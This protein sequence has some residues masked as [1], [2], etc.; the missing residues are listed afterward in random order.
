MNCAIASMLARV[1]GSWVLDLHAR[2][3]NNPSIC[4]PAWPH[5][6]PLTSPFP[7]SAPFTCT[8]NVEVAVAKI[9]RNRM[10]KIL[11]ER[12]EWQTRKDNAHEG[13]W[14]T[15][16]ERV[17]WTDRLLVDTALPWNRTAFGPGGAAIARWR[18]KEVLYRRECTSTGTGFP[19]CTETKQRFSECGKD[20]PGGGHNNRPELDAEWAPFVA[21][22]IKRVENDLN[23]ALDKVTAGARSWPWFKPGAQK[24]GSPPYNTYRDYT[25]G[26]FGYARRAAPSAVTLELPRGWWNADV[27]TRVG[28]WH[29]DERVT[30]WFVNDQVVGVTGSQTVDTGGNWG[31]A[32][33]KKE[34]VLKPNERITEVQV[35]AGDE[36]WWALLKTNLG[37]TIQG[38]GSDCSDRGG[39]W[40]SDIYTYGKDGCAITTRRHGEIGT[41]DGEL[42]ARGL[43]TS[44]QRIVVI[45]DSGKEGGRALGV[46]FVFRRAENHPPCFG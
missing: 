25:Q 7:S 40:G 1:P 23:T 4:R 28:F 41:S 21:G 15:V 9:K 16:T 31:G 14:R 30:A 11:V 39:R 19:S 35:R 44:L 32:P 8:Q 6:S 24:C 12:K 27:T 10:D 43:P 26:P 34:L 5:R 37:N 42:D 46:Q 2:F 18:L 33:Q 36:V 13:Q 20:P 29:N 17:D 22:Y 45:P 3:I 38:G